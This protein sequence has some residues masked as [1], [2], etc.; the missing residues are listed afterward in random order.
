[1]MNMGYDAVCFDLDG[2]LLDTSE[3]IALATG[4][5]IERFGLSPLTDE[6]QKSFIG[7]PIQ[8]SF[9]RRYGLTK[10]RAWELATAW[11]DAYKDLFLLKARP[12]E[13]IY[14]VL[15]AIRER[16][17]RTGVA[18][19]KREDYARKLLEN[20]SFTELFDHI[21]GTELEGRLKKLDLIR[22]CMDKLGVSDGKRCLM[23]GDT[24]NDLEAAKT[25]G[26]DFLGVTY[27]FEFT[28]NSVFPDLCCVGVE[29]SPSAAR[30]AI[31]SVAMKGIG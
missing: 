15:R 31:E 19:N 12:Y 21:A 30:E 20:F 11:R 10:E 14:E 16:G 27:G 29:S 26:M 24:S 6:E 3:G 18:T 7:P 23:V 8:D 2:T 1:M 5:V 13:G 17:I 9:Q 4:Q 25:A 28:E 22:V